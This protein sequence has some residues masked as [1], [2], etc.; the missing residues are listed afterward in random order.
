MKINKD[1][2]LLFIGDSITDCDRAKPEGEG[3]FGA[4]G[5]GYVSFVNAFLTSTYPEL[6]IRVV[7]KGISGNK[8]RD[9]KAR[10]QEDVVDQKPD[11]LVVMIGI[12]DVWRQYD[13]PFMKD[14]HVYIEEYEKTLR[15]LIESTK[16]TVEGLVLMTPYYLEPNKEDPMRKTM[17]AYG[18]VVKKIAEETNSI[19]I[20]TQA[21]F[22]KLMENIYPA[23]LA[24]DRVHPNDSG[25]ILLAR[26]FLTN[27]GFDWTK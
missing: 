11:W 5:N 20:D 4:Y 6:G 25:H 8:V 16:P 18:A 27:I 10:W 26:T 14:H 17:D 9:L 23:A 7:N 13:I 1:K 2:K 19:F 21:A 12:N 24:W 3:M 22:D 15:E